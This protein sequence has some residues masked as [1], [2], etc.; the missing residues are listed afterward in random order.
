MPRKVSDP[1]QKEQTEQKEQTR[2]K[3]Q[4]EQRELK[5]PREQPKAPPVAESGGASKEATEVFNLA[6]VEKF[7]K[8]TGCHPP[9]PRTQADPQKAPLRSEKDIRRRS[10]RDSRQ[11]EENVSD[12]QSQSTRGAF[13]SEEADGEPGFVDD[14]ELAAVYRDVTRTLQR[15]LARRERQVAE[16]KARRSG[17]MA[18]RSD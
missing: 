17:E 15:D 8:S 12:R 9:S 16:Q 4:R 1:A 5:E 7:L 13:L 6:D 14:P 10:D 11:P 18:R 3:I 2:L